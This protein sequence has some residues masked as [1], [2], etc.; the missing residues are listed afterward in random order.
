MFCFEKINEPNSNQCS[1]SPPLQANLTSSISG[2][3]ED[4]ESS[5]GNMETY[6]NILTHSG[7]AP[8]EYSLWIQSIMQG[9]Y[10]LARRFYNLW[11]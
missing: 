5:F 8:R 1:T 6:E 7:D 10:S 11:Q 2:Q 3:N 9:L 4:H